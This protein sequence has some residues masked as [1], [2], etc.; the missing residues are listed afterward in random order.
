MPRTTKTRPCPHCGAPAEVTWDQTMALGVDYPV[1]EDVAGFD[2]P[3]GCELPFRDVQ[4]TYPTARTQ[5]QQPAAAPLDTTSPGSAPTLANTTVPDPTYRARTNQSA[6]PITAFVSWAHRPNPGTTAESW[7]DQVLDLTVGLRRSGVD[8]DIDLFHLSDPGVDWTRYGT[9]RI[10]DSDR[11]V[12]VLNT[13]WRER[14]EGRNRPTEGAGAV[15]EAD[16]LLSS[17]ARDQ[18]LFRRRVVLLLL[19]GISDDDVPDGWHGVQR[20]RVADSTPAG[21]TDLLRLLTDQPA[22]IA[23]PLGE[24][25]VLPPVSL[26][27]AGQFSTRPEPAPG[28]PGGETVHANVSLTRS[29]SDTVTTSDRVTAGPVTPGRDDAGRGDQIAVLESALR[30]MPS[31]EV[32]DGPHL[33]W[34]RQSQQIR[35]ELMQLR[36]QV[37]EQQRSAHAAAEAATAVAA[38]TQL[39]ELTAEVTTHLDRTN[40]CWVLLALTADHLGADDPGAGV[41]E[42]RLDRRRR[43]VTDWTARTSPIVDVGVFTAVRLPGRVLFPGEPPIST[44]RRF[45][46]Y[47]DGRGVAAAAVGRFPQL[48]QRPQALPWKDAHGHPPINDAIYLPLPRHQL[49]TWLLTQLELLADHAG[50]AGLDPA[51]TVFLRAQLELPARLALPQV[52][53]PSGPVRV[54]DEP[55]DPDGQPAGEA[56]VADARELSGAA[57]SPATP[58]VSLPLS[59]L[60]DPASRVRTARRVAVELL[61]HF[62]VEQ[63]VLL[64][65]DGTLNAFSPPA[66]QEQHLVHQHAERLGLPTD[67]HSPLTRRSH[68]EDHLAQARAW[69]VP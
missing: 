67:P 24:L 43:Q 31:P 47:D 44:T 7:R 37:T 9:S 13:A 33:P 46:L 51:A 8:A 32:G 56:P 2:C 58:V 40:R 54:I 25:P 28:P 27:G 17:F 61:E 1:R 53:A 36:A 39:A 35:Q 38:A 41:G 12:V 5:P 16:A 62:G 42:S 49:E 50:C 21:L 23:P 48:S 18:D 15:A 19:P 52:E 63:T 26:G 22:F 69:L 55:R 57:S 45:E 65:P 29:T 14:R 59:T 4:R 20:C 64:L 66:D 6:T 30:Q 11:V 60:N 10:A 34:V 3:S 68:Y